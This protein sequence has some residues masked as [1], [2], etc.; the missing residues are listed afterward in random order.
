MNIQNIID[1]AQLE[2][3][4]TKRMDC[5]ICRGT[6]TFTITNAMGKIIWNCY[7]ASC[8]VSGSKTG[9]V[10]AETIERAMLGK[11]VIDYDDFVLPSHVV[12]GGLRTQIKRFAYEFGIHPASVP[13]YYDVRENRVVFPIR[14]DHKNVDAIGRSLGMSLPKWKRYGKS[15]TP[16]TYGNGD[17]AVIV[18]DC[19]SATVLGNNKVRG[20]ALLGT[21][22]SDAHR[23]YL[24]QF[25]TII[26]A[27]DP[28]ALSK[29]LS[30]ASELRAYK[31]NVKVLKLIDDLK[32]CNETDFINLN[33][34]IG[35]R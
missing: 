23:E 1:S 2:V 8:R 12:Y 6:K 4:Q 24:M 21:S 30:I 19:I 9:K 11:T 32:Y 26:V 3:G 34:L 28:D 25:S 5:P 18:E 33:K 29:T 7:K 27:L 13:L 10:S 15:D 14:K 22:L 17:V 35:D 31:Q 16:Y 20:V